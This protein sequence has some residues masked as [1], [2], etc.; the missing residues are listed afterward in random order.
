[1][2]VTCEDASNTR[3]C[4]VHLYMVSRS[5]ASKGPRCIPQ[6][7][8]RSTHAIGSYVE[9]RTVLLKNH[10][11]LRTYRASFPRVHIVSPSASISPLTPATFFPLRIELRPPD[12]A[13]EMFPA[14]WIS[15]SS[16]VGG[17]LHGGGYMA[18]VKR[19]MGSI[20]YLIGS[21]SFTEYMP[22]K[23]YHQRTRCVTAVR[24]YAYQASH[25]SSLCN[26]RRWLCT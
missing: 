24:G 26:L 12:V 20:H 1:M 19:E 6:H 11:V 17:G 7:A 4:I 9:R 14:V 22:A 2:N 10:H 3:G 8:L 23:W 16:Q 15:G 13:R 21:W 25:T 5:G 18:G